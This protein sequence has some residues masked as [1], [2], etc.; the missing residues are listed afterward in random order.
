MHQLFGVERA[1][2]Q[3]FDLAA[4][5]HGDGLHGRSLAVFRCNDFVRREVEPRLG[6]CGAD[7]GLRADQDWQDEIGAGRF[8]SAKQRG[9]VDRM[10]NRGRIGRDLV[11]SQ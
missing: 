6:G 9:C 7:F 4:P 5:S 11:S 2:H 10:D 1:L 3:G 8:G